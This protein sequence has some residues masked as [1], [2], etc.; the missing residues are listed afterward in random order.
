[1]FLWQIQ[2]FK[3]VKRRGEL[4]KS[5]IPTCIS[6]LYFIFSICLCF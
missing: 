6:C 3:V 4:L 1:M 2:L 5:L